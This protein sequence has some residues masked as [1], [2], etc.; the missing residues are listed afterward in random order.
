M[1][2][3]FLY[4]AGMYLTIGALMITLIAPGET[5]DVCAHL[6]AEGLAE[7]VMAEMD[8]AD[9][10]EAKLATVMVLATD[11]ECWHPHAELGA[12]IDVS[13]LARALG[14]TP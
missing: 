10:A 13:V 1:S 7:Q 5:C 4:C 8:R 14:V 6:E 2:Q 9:A 11:A 12:V 3:R